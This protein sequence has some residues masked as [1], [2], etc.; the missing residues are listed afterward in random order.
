MRPTFR[1]EAG[2]PTRVVWG[3]AIVTHEGKLEAVFPTFEAADDWFWARHHFLGCITPVLI[4]ERDILQPADTVTYVHD[5][6]P[7]T[8][9]AACKAPSFVV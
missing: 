8:G 9:N 1:D 2:N 6:V 4:Y 7:T 5:V 3:W